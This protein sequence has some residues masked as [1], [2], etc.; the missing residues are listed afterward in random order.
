MAAI[1]VDVEED[2]E[3]NTALL[4]IIGRVSGIIRSERNVKK[5][6][7]TALLIFKI[8]ECHQGTNPRQK[9]RVAVDGSYG[10]NYYRR[11]F[12]PVVKQVD[13]TSV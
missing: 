5:V 8:T 2:N 13:R 1:D 11:G 4:W 6:R 10:P 12:G 7:S 9:V 3:L